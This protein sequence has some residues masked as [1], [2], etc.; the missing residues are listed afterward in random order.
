MNVNIVKNE[1]IADGIFRLTV[2]VPEQARGA[3]AGQFINLY[4]PDADLLLPRP[5]GITDAYDDVIEIVYAVIGAGT[6]RLSRLK[7]GEVIRALGPNGTGFDLAAAERKVLLIGGGLGI[8]PLLFAARKLRE[9]AGPEGGAK[10]TALLGFRDRPYYSSEFR[11]YCDRVFVISEKRNASLPENASLDSTGVERTGTVVD[12][13]N[14]L[15]AEG[16]LAVTGTSILACGPIPMLRAVGE[17]ASER[18]IRAQFSL[19]AR[20]GCGY[21]ACVGCSIELRDLESAGAGTVK[22]KVCTNG[23]VFDA[24]RIVWD[25]L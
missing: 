9:N 5:F 17:W 7:A 12:L 3:Q 18:G 23:P 10:I 1:N 2:S 15:V 14:A 25:G 4:L 8:P 20:M 19:E 13:M 21:G 11:A 22:Q 16:E 6:E 24:E